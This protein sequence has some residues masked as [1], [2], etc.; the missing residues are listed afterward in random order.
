M[1]S[2]DLPKLAMVYIF[3]SWEA[4]EMKGTHRAMFTEEPSA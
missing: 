2:L 1:M 3:V 4:V